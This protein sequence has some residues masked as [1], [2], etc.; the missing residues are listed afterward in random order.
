MPTTQVKV[1]YPA[2]LEIIHGITD[3]SI[4]LAAA[5]RE[6]GVDA[7]F[8]S[9]TRSWAHAFFPPELKWNDV[10]APRVVHLQWPY[11]L[12]GQR[13]DRI[14]AYVQA[15]VLLC[16]ERCTGASVVITFHEAGWYFWC[17]LFAGSLLLL[18]DKV[19][20]TVP[21]LR[22]GIFKTL[23]SFNRL[24]KGEPEII[25][26]GSNIPVVAA[27]KQRVWDVVYFGAIRRNKGLEEILALSTQLAQL[28][29]A[30]DGSAARVVLMGT[31]DADAQQWQAI[32]NAVYDLTAR[33]YEELLLLVC[34]YRKF[35]AYLE[36]KPRRLPVDCYF[37]LPKE[38]I[39]ERLA[40]Y[41]I[42]Y[43]P[44]P[45]SK[46]G[47]N[48]QR[49]APL[50]AMEHG[51]VV[52]SHVGDKTSKGLQQAVLKASTTQEAVGH[53]KELWG[54]PAYL[55]KRR[56]LSIRYAAS[57]WNDIARSHIQL[58]AGLLK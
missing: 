44:Y 15:F 3:Y 29:L 2:G 49:G 40:S 25:P 58:Y 1:V 6:Q 35:N 28:G 16:R 54:D 23:R 48:E 5:L 32:I 53:I 19:V 31:I 39:S 46:G 14:K 9:F 50:A 22:S 55:E 24:I 43:Y 26:I 17:D 11:S 56:E 21:S 36:T 10:H 12:A 51:I 30:P 4:R 27:T 45:P 20:V 38:D 41:A 52:I 18:A 7:D 34:D 37:N 42:A 33:E 47:I 13:A 8:H 57:R